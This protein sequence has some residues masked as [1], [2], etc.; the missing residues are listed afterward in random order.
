MKFP[1]SYEMKSYEIAIV[2][3]VGL[4]GTSMDEIKENLSELQELAHAA[5]AKVLAVTLQRLPKIHP[6][7]LIGR[8]KAEEIAELVKGCKASL[9]IVDHPLSGVQSRNLEKKMEAR[10]LDRSQLILDIFAQRARTY[11]GKLQVE[12]AQRLDQMP[13]M[14]GAWHGSLSRQ[15][16]GIG[17]RGPGEKALEIDRRSI[18]ERVKQIRQKLE[19]VRSQRSQ[20]RSQR[21]RR[22]VPSFSLIGYTNSGKSTL[23]NHLT[24]SNVFVKNQLFA[25]LDPTT[26]KVY[27]PQIGEA[28]ITDTVGFIRKLPTHLIEAFKATLEESTEADVLLHVIDLSSPHMEKHIQVVNE[29]IDELGWREKPILHVFNKVDLA[30]ASKF[31]QIKETPRVFISAQRGEGIEKLKQWMCQSLQKQQPLLELFFP[32]L[33]EHKIY[34]LG[35]QA[36]LHKV[37][38]G[39]T[40]TICHVFLSKTQLGPWQKYLVRTIFI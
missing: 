1:P 21:R 10:V 8:G 32:Q 4:K 35:H 13:R 6:A 34:E 30:S 15:G 5:G 17:T 31:F 7:T 23:L 26:R 9:V 36:K 22:Q 37:E 24:R 39:S 2:V 40:G 12:L 3:G 28:V 11:E 33:E 20:H 29:L 19:L 14:V 16:G 25:T 18:Q 38:K 27:L